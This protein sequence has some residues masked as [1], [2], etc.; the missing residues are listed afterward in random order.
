MQIVKEL[1]LHGFE[2]RGELLASFLIIQIQVASI[3]ANKEAQ[4]MQSKL[5][6]FYL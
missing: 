2:R 1:L 6:R 3:S 5:I 4:A